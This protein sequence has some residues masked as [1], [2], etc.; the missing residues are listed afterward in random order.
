ML[1]K[2]CTHLVS[3]SAP[4]RFPR[5]GAPQ[6]A[7]MGRSNVGKSSLINRMLGTRGLAR[8]SKTPGRTR[9]IHFYRVNRKIDFVDLP[10][11]GYARVP[12]PMREEWKGL[13]EA[14]LEGAPG[15][16]LAVVLVDARHPPTE[17]DQELVDWLRSAGRRSRIALTKIDKLPRGRWAS[18]VAAAASALG[19]PPDALPIPVSAVTKEGIPAL[20]RVVDAACERTRGDSTPPQPLKSPHVP[21]GERHHRERQRHGA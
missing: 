2:E 5:D 9:E 20:W 18:A 12:K 14:Y 13:V 1:V 10:G 4:D 17:M 6:I 15:P 7:F 19:T 8:T 11:Y 3:A 16:D 21:Q